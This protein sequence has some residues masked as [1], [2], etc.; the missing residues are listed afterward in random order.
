MYTSL[1]EISIFA[2]YLTA[3]LTAALVGLFSASYGAI[4][5]TVSGKAKCKRIRLKTK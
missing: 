3:Y 5:P 1:Y 4:E 2:R